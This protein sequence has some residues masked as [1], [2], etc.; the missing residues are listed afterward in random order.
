MSIRAS[1][2]GVSSSSAQV[3]VALWFQT[4]AGD[5]TLS[6]DVGAVEGTV[7]T[8]YREHHCAGRRGCLTIAKPLGRRVLLSRAMLSALHDTHHAAMNDSSSLVTIR[9][10]HV[11][12]DGA[13][14][15]VYQLVPVR[16]SRTDPPGDAD[17]ELLLGVW[18]D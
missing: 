6:S 9:V 18:P 2:D 5:T 3:P 10:D 15:W 8:D 7:A 13:A 12:D 4:G 14:E 17:P 11:G 1:I 16:W